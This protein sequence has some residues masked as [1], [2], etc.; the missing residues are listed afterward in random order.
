MPAIDR[1]REKKNDEDQRLQE[2]FQRM[3]GIRRPGTGVDRPVMHEME[4]L[5]K[6]GVM[7]ESMHPVKIG[8]VDQEH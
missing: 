2:G 8:I 4:P 7:D 6:P 1:Y 3:K 5:K